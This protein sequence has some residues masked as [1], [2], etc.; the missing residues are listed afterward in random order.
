[1]AIA[2][3]MLACRLAAKSAAIGEIWGK[4]QAGHR[5]QRYP[6]RSHARYVGCGLEASVRWILRCQRMRRR[7]AHSRCGLNAT[8]I[9]DKAMPA[10]AAEI[11]SPRL[12]TIQV[13]TDRDTLQS[14]LAQSA[15]LTFQSAGAAQTRIDLEGADEAIKA[16]NACVK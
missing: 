14:A 2:V 4:H 6:D 1:M 16:L 11:R 3:L 15:E 7:A 8:L 5:N 10:C 12:L 9:N 13:G